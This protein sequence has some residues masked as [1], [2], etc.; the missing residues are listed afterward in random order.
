MAGYLKR[1]LGVLQSQHLTTEQ[2][3]RVRE[4][5]A[6]DFLAR[7]PIKYFVEGHLVENIMRLAFG[8]EAINVKNVKGGISYFKITRKSGESCSIRFS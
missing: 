8:K 5:I 3:N 6:Q 1:M 2:Q 4:L 7:Q